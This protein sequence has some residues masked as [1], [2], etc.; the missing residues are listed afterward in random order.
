MHRRAFRPLSQERDG[1]PAASEVEV[2]DEADVLGEDDGLVRRF[3]VDEAG[4]SLEVRD[5]ARFAVHD[6]LT[7]KVEAVA[8]DYRLEGGDARSE[9]H[10]SELPSLMRISY[11]VCCLK[12]NTKTA[13]N[14]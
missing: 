9:E 12:K 1:A 6:R 3:A 14:A 8:R 5:L 4:Q 13:D 11:A 10:T 2:L 7:R